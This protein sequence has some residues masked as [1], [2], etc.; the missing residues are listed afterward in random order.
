MSLPTPFQIPERTSSKR[1][2]EQVIEHDLKEKKS[3]ESAIYSRRK[4]IKAQGSFDAVY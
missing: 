4:E 1:A 3:F 2:L